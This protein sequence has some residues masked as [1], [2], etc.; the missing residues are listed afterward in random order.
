MKCKCDKC[1][2]RGWRNRFGELRFFEQFWKPHRVTCEACEGKG[3]YHRE[4]LPAPDA[5]ENDDDEVPLGNLAGF[6]KNMGLIASETRVLNTQYTETIGLERQGDYCYIADT[7]SGECITYMRYIRNKVVQ[8]IK[9][10]LGEERSFIQPPADRNAVAIL[11]EKHSLDHGGFPVPDEIAKNLKRFIQM[12]GC[13][14]PKDGD[15]KAVADGC[16]VTDEESEAIRQHL[17]STKPEPFDVDAAG[18][19]MRDMLAK[20]AK[21]T[22]GATASLWEAGI[23]CP[24]SEDEKK[25]IRERVNRSL[26]GAT[27]E[28]MLLPE[29]GRYR[30]NGSNKADRKELDTPFM[31]RGQAMTLRKY[32]VDYAGLDPLDLPAPPRELDGAYVVPGDWVAYRPEKKPYSGYTKECGTLKTE[33]DLD[34][35]SGETT[36]GGIHS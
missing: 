31:A 3:Y 32:L 27:G 8:M 23:D 24:L 5:E 19:S 33:N 20:L 18:K 12:P 25:R 36:K 21:P 4:E 28:P 26:K 11:D 7:A 35:R 14:W 34:S 22:P 10:Q 13:P 9:D 1:R 17:L 29:D 15:F 30:L 2:G 16:G 6:I